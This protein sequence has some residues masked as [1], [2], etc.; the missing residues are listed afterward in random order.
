[1]RRWEASIGRLGSTLAVEG[2]GEVSLVGTQFDKDR[3]RAL[4]ELV[5]TRLPAGARAL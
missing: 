3:L 4:D 5:A 2:D 1:V